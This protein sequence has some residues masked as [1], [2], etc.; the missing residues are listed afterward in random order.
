MPYNARWR[1]LLPEIIDYER[2]LAPVIDE[3]RPDVLHAHDMQV[4]GI[5]AEAV[6]RA[7][8]AGRE[9]PWIYDAHEFVPGLSQYGDR[10]RRVIAAW[11]DLEQEYVHSAT[12]VITV[13][14]PISAELQ[15]IYRLPHPPAVVLNAPVADPSEGS[16][17]QLRQV[18]GL[19][20]S[21][22]LVVYSGMMTT[23]RGVHT[24]IEAMSLLPG[25][26]LALV[27]VPHTGTWSV[28]RLRPLATQAGLDARVHFLEPV[29]PGEV[30]EFLRSADLGLLPFQHFPS[31][32][33][34]LANKMFEYVER[35]AP[36]RGQ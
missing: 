27:C 5:A 28:R 1:I 23:A 15:R 12:R 14:S 22:P 31:H 7:R 2:A 13:S 34:A 26:H 36:G 35:R 11:T 33:M 6:E 17:P 3:L 30:V 32:E 9:V 16:P 18:V 21:I 8:S 29:R 10:T 25:V 24:A 20:D 4:V 19:P